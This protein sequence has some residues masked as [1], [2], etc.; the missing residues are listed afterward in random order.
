MRIHACTFLSAV[1]ALLLA[2]TA[3]AQ[4][5]TLS[6]VEELARMG[7]AEE[8]RVELM[9]WWDRARDD[10]SARDLQLGLW[11][12]GR[13]TVDPEQAELDFQRLVVL[14]PSSQYAP[15]ALFRLAQASFAQGDPETAR[16]HVATLVRDYPSSESRRQA[17]AWL[18]NPGAPSVQAATAS[19]PSRDGATGPSGVP[20]RS[21]AD[22]AAD[23]TA[24]ADQPTPPFRQAR[25]PAEPEIWFVQ[26]GAFADE[27]RAFAL[28]EEL[29]DAGLPARLVSVEGSAFLHVR[30]GRFTTREEANAQLE[31]VRA[32]GYSASIVRDERAE[33]TVRR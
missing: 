10:S 25:E 11:L 29:V 31:Q 4:S 13:L 32:R 3:S 18:A 30:I 15:Q 2:G 12:R 23:T 16:R 9:D 14:Y 26:F 27:S 28:H 22:P 1:A 7:R 6:R 20:A 8:A 21:G 5:P 19:R 17:E 24:A 33:T